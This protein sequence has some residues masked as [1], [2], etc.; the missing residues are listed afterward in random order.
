MAI[1]RKTIVTLCALSALT[2]NGV[3]QATD[4]SLLNLGHAYPNVA[5]SGVLGTQGASYDGVSLNIT[6]TLTNLTFTVGGEAEYIFGGTL[7]LNATFDLNGVI[8]SGTYSLTGTSTD[9]AT[10]TTYN[11]ELLSGKVL[12][13][14]FINISHISGGTDAADFALSVDGGT[15]KPLFDSVSSLGAS[16]TISLE[17]STYDGT[18]ANAWTAAK[19]KGDLGPIPAVE[20]LPQ[21][22]IGFWKNHLDVW[23]YAPL[24]ICQNS[25]TQD[26]AVS[27]L[28]IPAKGDKTIVMAKQL[29]A[30]K[31]NEYV[32]NSCPTAISDAEAW[33]CNHGGIGAK[34][35]QWDGGEPLKNTLD[36][37]N[38]GASCP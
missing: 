30:A 38:N 16:A 32:G 27:V 22:T 26:A 37:F 21:H 28:S 6:S 31:L 35:R 19:A 18:F 12:D 3:S 5:F 20:P 23:T 8:D 15:L 1:T 25:L 36:E 2:F 11:G 10:G 14:G 13:Y 34:R 29:I 4:G 33:L 9:S 7:T 17:G 24:T